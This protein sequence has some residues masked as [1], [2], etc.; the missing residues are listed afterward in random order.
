M[1][2]PDIDGLIND[3]ID[4]LADD[5]PN[6]GAECLVELAQAWA[7]CSLTHASFEAMRIYIVEQAK[8]RDQCPILI[9]MKL[10]ESEKQ[11]QRVRNGESTIIY[12]N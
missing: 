5:N 1:S 4:A 11:L 12:F 9:E 6:Y 10:K 3:T 8:K 7:S 2:N